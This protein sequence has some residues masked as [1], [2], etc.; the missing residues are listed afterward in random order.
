MMQ[1]ARFGVESQ[2]KGTG[3]GSSNEEQVWNY[4]MDNH[5]NWD[6]KDVK[7]LYL[8]NRGIYKDVSLVV[9][10]QSTEAFAEFILK[11]MTSQNAIT[12]V[13]VFNMM[14]PRLFSLPENISQN[15]KRFTLTLNVIPR[16]APFIY[17]TLS[18]IKPSSKIVITYLTFVYH[19]H[20]DILVSL[21][22][23][24]KKAAEDFVQRYINGIKGVI[25]AELTPIIR[26]KNLATPDEWKAYCGQ[27]F[28]IKDGKQI[29][30]L[31]I[32]ENW[33]KK[34]FE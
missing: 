11:Y 33:S 15:M 23:G 25:R 28:I 7:S 17:G 24:D 18:K 31:E 8:T 19:K 22:A 10:S 3:A 34:G 1:I 27:Y 4:I 5:I 21:L 20:G 12:D 13:W 29:E 9:S 26:S 14:E 2:D 6:C 30:D 32:Y 16:G